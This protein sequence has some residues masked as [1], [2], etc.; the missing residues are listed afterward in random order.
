MAK[1]SKVN[2][3][4]LLHYST[5]TFGLTTTLGAIGLFLNGLRQKPTR[6]PQHL[7]LSHTPDYLKTL[8]PPYNDTVV[9]F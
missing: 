4:N 1:R 2:E 3:I 5:S 9:L 7:V 6:Y 8:P